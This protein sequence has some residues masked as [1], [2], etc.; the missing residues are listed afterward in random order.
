MLSHICVISHGV[1]EVGGEVG[2]AD[3][4][5]DDDTEY[6]GGDD[7]AG[8][9]EDN[10]GHGDDDDKDWRRGG[11][12]RDRKHIKIAT[13][14]GVCQ[15]SLILMI[16]VTAGY[17]HQREENYFVPSKVGNQKYFDVL[18]LMQFSQDLP[19]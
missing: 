16:S 4:L 15:Q 18:G 12:S 19:D 7:H 11:L 3:L 9:Q 2:S 14:G 10:H 8:Q 13:G 17:L 5:L 6:D 1:V